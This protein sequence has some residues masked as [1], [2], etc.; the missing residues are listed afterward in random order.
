MYTSTIHGD[1][2]RYIIPLALC[3]TM[4]C[5]KKQPSTAAEEVTPTEEPAPETTPEEYSG[6]KYS[7]EESS[8]EES[9]GEEMPEEMP[10]EEMPQE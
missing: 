3:F 5:N 7:G 6:E 2:M 10:E 8:G 4:A 1:I 9:S